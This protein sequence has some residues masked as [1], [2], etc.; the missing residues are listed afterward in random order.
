MRAIVMLGSLACATALTRPA[1]AVQCLRGPYLQD[2]ATGAVTIRWELDQL[3]SSSVEFG[4]PGA[5]RQRVDCPFQGRKHRVRLTGLRPGQR[6]RYRVFAK[7]QPVTDEFEFRATPTDS[8]PYTF[9]VFGDCGAGSR[10]QLGV[11]KLLEQSPA[12]F[13][14]LCGDIVY[15]H[16]EEEDYDLRFFEPYR[17]ALPRMTFW[18]A[19]GNHDVGAKDAAAA[20]AIFNV[21][22]NGPRNIQG[23]RNYSFDYGNAH[24]AA[25]DSNASPETLRDLIGPWLE[26]DMAASRQT[27]KFVFFHHPPFSS[28]NHGEN[29]KMRDLMVPVFIRS[30]IDVVFAG[31]DHAYERTQ[32]I[33]GIT[34]IVTGDGGASLYQHQHPHDYTAQF[35]NERHGLTLV[36]IDGPHF[37]LRHVNVDGKEV[38]RLELT[39][40]GS[41]RAAGG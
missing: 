29:E 19:L 7:G 3:G 26:K 38:D 39:K 27:W 2:A 4:P 9:A 13:V 11:A 25:I 1:L 6:Y 17:R 35:Y 31:H 21:P 20:L 8:G 16:G 32:P 5:T 34:Y 23:G 41:R 36:K 40:P 12:E 18:P 22:L 37:L 33:N 14:L 15:D 28:A 24:I 10:G 30:R